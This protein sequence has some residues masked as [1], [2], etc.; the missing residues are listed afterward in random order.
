MFWACAA[1]AREPA[2]SARTRTINFMN[3]SSL[4]RPILPYA[5]SAQHLCAARSGIGLDVG[6]KA[7]AMG[8]H[9]HEQRPEAAHP[10]LPQRLRVQVVEVHVLDGLHP[11]GLERRRAADNGEV[12]PAQILE[13]FQ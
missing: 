9:G 6:V 8:V 1:R 11:G 13:R 4:K 7:L 2:T 10:E 3:S 5:E 12:R